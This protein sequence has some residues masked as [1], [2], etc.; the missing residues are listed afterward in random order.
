MKRI[1]YGELPDGYSIK[2]FAIRER[3]VR[4]DK[5]IAAAV[6]RFWPDTNKPGGDKANAKAVEA[7]RHCL[8]EV[9]GTP[10]N[11][12]SQ[13]YMDLDNWTQMTLFAVMQASNDAFSPLE[14]AEGKLKKMA[15]GG[16]RV[17]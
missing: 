2:T 5:A 1:Y 8:V 3:I 4:D 9:D 11:T 6:D 7:V 15:K 12:D 17:A 16:I 10:V 13:P 14:D